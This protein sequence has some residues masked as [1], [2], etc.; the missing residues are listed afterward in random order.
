MKTAN[1]TKW[2]QKAMARRTYIGRKKLQGSWYFVVHPDELMMRGGADD[3][4][5]L[6]WLP[7]DLENPLIMLYSNRCLAKKEAGRCGGNV[8]KY[9]R[10]VDYL[11]G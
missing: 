8:E 6:C 4:L 7:L 10:M 2:Q 3:G 11:R 1:Q 5:G 9:P